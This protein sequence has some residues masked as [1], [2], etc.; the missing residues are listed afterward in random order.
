MPD[1]DERDLTLVFLIDALGQEIVE[2]SGFCERLISAEPIRVASILG[3]SSGAIPTILTGRLPNEHGHWSMYRRD[4]G[5]GVFRRYRWI[6]RFAASLPRGDWRFRR[7]LTDRLRA[8]GV[9]GYF[10]LYE[11]PLGLL[12]QFDLCER[13]NIYRP[14]AF[15]GDV[16]SLFDRLEREEVPY[17]VW[18]WSVPDDRALR[19]MEEAA[20]DGRERLLFF[21]SSV[22]DAT[23]HLQGPRSDATRIRLREYEE[24]IERV[25]AA[26]RAGGRNPRIRIFGDHGMAPVRSHFDLLGSLSGIDARVPDDYL[27]FVDSTMGR[28]WFRSD[29]A[30]RTILDRLSERTDGRFLDPGEMERLGVAFGDR[31]YGEEVFLADPGVLFVPSFMGSRPIAG[32]HGYHPEDPDSDTALLADPAPSR[33]V[34]TIRDLRGLLLHDLGIDAEG[35]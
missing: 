29:A 7:W 2:G 8:D 25:A 15:E 4:R 31:E 11:V 6:L 28:F 23:M 18:D 22:L 21:Y 16:E 14:G 9:T 20:R 26:A 19:E 30:R 3:F 24:A 27:V 32:M 35:R 34:R 33:P 5:R 12:S 17:R 13:R 1:T 10:S